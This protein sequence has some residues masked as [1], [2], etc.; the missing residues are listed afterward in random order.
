MWVDPPKKNGNKLEFVCTCNNRFKEVLR[1]NFHRRNC[2]SSA[3][4]VQ[5]VHM[6]QKAYVTSYMLNTN[7]AL[8]SG[9]GYISGNN[10]VK[11]LLQKQKQKLRKT[12]QKNELC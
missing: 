11:E 5:K 2:I 4:R 7:L 12:G 10:Q 8:Y 3:H 1:S 6:R 9:L